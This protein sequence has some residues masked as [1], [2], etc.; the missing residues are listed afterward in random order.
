MCTVGVSTSTYSNHAPSVVIRMCCVFAAYTPALSLS[1]EAH[2]IPV[3]Y[4]YIVEMSGEGEGGRVTENERGG[5]G[6]G[7]G[8]ERGEKGGR[9]GWQENPPVVCTWT[10]SSKQFEFKPVR[11]SY[12]CLY[13]MKI[14]CLLSLN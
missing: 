10:T 7:K 3:V 6:R 5:G 4:A 12:S 14:E 2:Q 11:F 13:E 9:V 8:T 1:L